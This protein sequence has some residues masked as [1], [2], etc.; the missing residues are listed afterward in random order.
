GAA[1]G[2]L[3]ETR[4]A[5]G[6]PTSTGFVFELEPLAAGE[7]TQ[8]VGGL[9]TGQLDPEVEW[10]IVEQAGGNPLFAEQLLAHALEAP[11]LA[12]E[13]PPTVEALLASRLDRLVPQELYALRRASVV[14]RRFTRTELADL[15]P[16]D[17]L[18]AT[19]RRLATLGE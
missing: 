1:R 3:L 13:L 17:E 15:T 5:W 8:L 10:Q 2:E 12:D 19:E 16:D 9:A 7:V 4:P 18:R 14:G 11:D 6:G